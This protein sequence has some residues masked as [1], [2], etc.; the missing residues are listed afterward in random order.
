MIVQVIHAEMV[1]HATMESMPIRAAA[2]QA[3][4]DEIARWVSY[5]LF[6]WHRIALNYTEQNL[7]GRY[8]WDIIW[9]RIR[10]NIEFKRV[11]KT[12]VV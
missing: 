6:L 10:L 1:V 5:V 7:M 11:S 8:V 2:S 9:P 3:L 4:E 12:S